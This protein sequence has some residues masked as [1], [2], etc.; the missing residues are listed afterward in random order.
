MSTHRISV[1]KD[2]EMVQCFKRGNKLWINYTL[3]GKR[4]KKSTGLDDNAKNRKLVNFT[5]IPQLLT[6]IVTGEIY[7]KKS[8]S[9]QFYGEIFLKQK[10]KYLR[11]YHTRLPYF[12]R[13]LEHF[14]ETDIDKITRLDVKKFLFGLKM[15]SASKGSY[16]SCINEIFE[17]AVD[18]GVLAHNPALNI[19]LPKDVKSPIRYFYEY[20]VEKLL[21]VAT[22]KMKVY[23]LLAFN[24][25]MRPEEILGLQFTDVKDKIITISRVRTKG[26]VDY[27]KTNNSF[28]K[29]AIPQ[30]I[31]DSIN[32]LKSD[33]LYLFGSMDDSSKLR[34]PWMKIV[35]EADV[36]Y[37]KISSARHTFATIMLQKKLVSLNELSGLLGHSSPKVTL[38]HYASVIDSSLIDLGE[39]FSLFGHN[40]VT[41]EDFE[42]RN[43]HG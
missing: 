9:F 2:R 20:E 42:V 30:F 11:A 22:G 25:G 7:K 17:L 41:M 35:N 18:D 19:R 15:K 13:V 23:L 32:Q 10:E 36:E 4:Y 6:K 29:L 33:S 37:R 16:K 34:K 40:T 28:R 5:I 38:A 8:K 12:L 31:V 3:D 24:T 39:N 1:R 21:R 43:A 26:R 14:G 27:P